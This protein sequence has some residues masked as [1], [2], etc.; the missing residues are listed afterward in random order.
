MKK[1]V[2]KESL[3]MESIN[4]I[5][6]AKKYIYIIILLFF[7]SAIFGFIFADKLS[8]INQILKELVDK[9]EGLGPFDLTVFIFL[10]NLQSA[11]LGMVLGLAFGIMPFVNSIGNGIV[12]GFVF[13]KVY[14][15]S[16]FSNFWRILPHGIFELPAIFIALGLG[17]Q[18][19]VNVIFN[20]RSLFYEL[21][22]AVLAFLL[23]V[24]PLLIIAAIIEGLLISFS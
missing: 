1:L 9:T 22:R 6:S 5:K 12:L 15:V 16:G 17:L 7:L 21:R 20:S 2:R 8:F 4:S 24:L 13:E 3:F 11:F 14:N 18:L 23:I 10:N 19:G